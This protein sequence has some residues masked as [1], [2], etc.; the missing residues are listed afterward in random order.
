MLYANCN[1]LYA[2]SLY[3]SKFRKYNINE[4][5]DKEDAAIK[6]LDY[7]INNNVMA[8]FFRERRNEVVNMIL[9]EYTKERVEQDLADM[10]KEIEDMK[11]TIAD[12]DIEIQSKDAEIAKLRQSLNIR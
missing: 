2:Y 12:K 4:D 6:A 11:H 5:E 9:D 7:C 3:I 1:A 10:A 8:D